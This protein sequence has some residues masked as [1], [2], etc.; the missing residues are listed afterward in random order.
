MDTDLVADCFESMLSV[1]NRKKSVNQLKGIVNYSSLAASYLE[2]TGILDEAA[3]TAYALKTLNRKVS[4]SSHVRSIDNVLVYV[5]L[6]SLL[7]IP[8]TTQAFKLGLIDK[9]GNLVREPVTPIEADAISN[10]DLFMAKLRTWL[11]P[12]LQKMSSMTWLRSAG[13]NDRIQ[14]SLSNADMVAKRAF[15]IRC[16]DELGKVL[17]Q[18]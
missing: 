7:T 12:H 15:V 2:G 3:H 13:G 8:T 9:D 11:R 17:R 14:N 5:F 6:K 1:L 4:M 10:L 18:K 16:N